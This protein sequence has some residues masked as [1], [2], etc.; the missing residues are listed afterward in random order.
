MTERPTAIQTSPPPRPPT[1]STKPSVAWPWVLYASEAGGAAADSEGG[2]VPALFVLF[3]P[4]RAA[5]DAL[6][7]VDLRDP[8]AVAQ[9]VAERMNASGGGPLYVAL[10]TAWCLS[11]SVSTADLPRRD[12]RRLLDYRLEERVPY[13]ME[14]LAV[15]YAAPGGGSGDGDLT[16]GVVVE[17]RRLEGLLAALDRAGIALAAVSP[18][19]LLAAQALVEGVDGGTGKGAKRATGAGSGQSDRAEVV[20]SETH[21]PDVWLVSC[22]TPRRGGAMEMVVFPPRGARGA[23]RLPVGWYGFGA[24]V[25]E[26]ATAL[27]AR[28][29]ALLEQAAERCG[30]PLRISLASKD[31]A[32]HAAL[33]ELP[34]V[35][36]VTV[37]PRPR[38]YGRH[39]PAG[40]PW[41]NL[42]RGALDPAADRR[43]EQ[44]F[45]RVS[46]ALM[47]LL[48]CLWLGLHIRGS[49]FAGVSAQAQRTQ[50]DV[51]REAA[52]PGR[53]VPVSF[54]RGLR[55]I[56]DEQRSASGGGN[57]DGADQRFF[58][59]L[60]AIPAEADVRITEI[61]VTADRV[62][63]VAQT[64]SSVDA[65]A[66]AAALSS[67][68]P[69]GI[70]FSHERSASAADVGDDD[71]AD[72]G[73]VTVDLV[74]VPLRSAGRP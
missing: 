5:G 24:G 13:A 46:V 74:G 10:D 25:S 62:D 14:D 60:R 4:T 72:G 55:A 15:D 66:L 22:P 23:R 2:G 21:E 34:D 67:T 64:A 27:G 32:L 52:G 19:T 31:P 26:G 33:R 1:T 59:T 63:L 36:H 71:G 65:G 45:G 49:R 40:D 7:G 56:L 68:G 30:R 6:A 9:A 37:V 29:R 73:A 41:I 53:R 61:R 47:V 8:E 69:D 3:G 43:L 54:T 50:A 51:F 11:V 44:R 58:A 57:S 42:R 18:A 16:L 48:A 17:T 38:G 20:A 70:V 28:P 12:R 39:M 35:E